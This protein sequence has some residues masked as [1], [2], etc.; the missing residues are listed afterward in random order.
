MENFV[1]FKPQTLKECVSLLQEH[2]NAVVMNG[3]TDIIVQMREGHIV[4]AV[5]VDVKNIPDLQGIKVS[6]DEIFIGGVATMS[7][8]IEHPELKVR[9]PYL[10]AADDSVG[11][12]QIRNRATIAGNIVNASPL[13]DTATPLLCLNAMVHTYGPNGTRAIPLTDFFVFVRKTLLEPHEIVT[14]ISFAA[15]ALDEGVF[16]KLARRAEVDLSTVCCTVGRKG[17][18]IRIAFGSVAPTPLR[19]YDVENYLKDKELTDEVISEARNI[20]RQSVKPISDVRATKEYRLD[21]VQNLLEDAL[22]SLKKE[23]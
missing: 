10:C 20:A 13:A 9:Y 1:Y 2:E 11:S 21:M 23:G 16:T 8:V 6:P 17:G 7:Q 4:P 18:E 15:D 22:R 12:I 5:I 3:G 14:G 19:L